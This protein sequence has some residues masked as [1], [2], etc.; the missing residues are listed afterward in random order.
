MNHFNEY[1]AYLKTRSNLGKL[2]RKYW[3]YPTL[4]RYLKGR[5][6]DIGC[7]LGDMLAYRALT[8]GVDINP[9]TVD[10]CRD[11]GL[12]AHLMLPDQLPFQNKYFDSVLL[13]N[14]F[15]HLENPN[16]LLGEIGRVL[17]DDGKLLFG[18]PGKHGWLSDSDHKVNYDEPSLKLCL[19]NAGFKC[20]EIFY[21]PFWRSSFLS[22]WVRL[23]CIY[24]CFVL[25]SPSTI[26]S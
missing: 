24:A 26:D 21:T 20:L 16:Q 4:S 1:F 22:K 3:L 13:D 9:L 14:V 10:Y 11:H 8:T 19:S 5:T 6:L 12:D 18:V 15:E 2:Y 7:G 23:Y 17:R 25:H